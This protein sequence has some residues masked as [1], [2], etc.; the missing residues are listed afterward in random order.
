MK[1]FRFLMIGICYM[2]CNAHANIPKAYQL[3]ADQY[4]LPPE[5]FFSIA[6][7]ESGKRNGN[8]FLPWPWT[9]NIDEKPYYFDTRE[10][11]EMALLNAMLKAK[12]EGKIGRVAVGIGQIYMPSHFAQFESPLQALDPTINL[13][14]AA[15]LLTTH[16]L[17]TIQQGKP[18]W[19][20][21]VGRYHSPTNTTL[22]SN[23]RRQVYNRCQRFSDKCSDFGSSIN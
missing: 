23:Y 6:M 10:Q 2:G 9:L 1:I 5:V 8:R 20:V 3:I 18:D 17:W 22:A 11:A 7:Q 15:K 12:R 13:N 14:Y 19:W 16:Y 21:A 4:G